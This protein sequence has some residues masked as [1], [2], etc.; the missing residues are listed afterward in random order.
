MPEVSG[1]AQQIMDLKRL[2]RINPEMFQGEIDPPG[3]RI[4]WIQIHHH[5]NDA[6]QVCSIFRVAEQF[7][8]IRGMELQMPIALQGRILTPDTIYQGDEVI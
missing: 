4:V 5:E 6:C 8:V 3:M 2:L 7:V 1:I